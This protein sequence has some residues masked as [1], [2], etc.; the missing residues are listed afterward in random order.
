MRGLYGRNLYGGDSEVS[1]SLERRVVVRKASNTWK[2]WPSDE[3]WKDT[4]S[5]ETKE[6]ESRT[7]PS[8][9]WMQLFLE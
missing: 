5:N 6:A 2:F 8:L 9:R 1:Y 7:A 4:G 3:S